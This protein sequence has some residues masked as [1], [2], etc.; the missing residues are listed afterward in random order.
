MP[1]RRGLMISIQRFRHVAIVASDLDV[2]LEFYTSV[3]GFRERSRYE[4]ASDDFR[5]GVGLPHVVAEVVHLGMVDSPVEIEMFQFDDTL[6]ACADRARANLPGYRHIAFVVEDLGAA[7]AQLRDLG[8][9]FFSNP[10]TLGA[11]GSVA[12]IQFVYFKD[13]EGNIVELNQLPP[14]R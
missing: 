8:V 12:G 4:S 10:I 6:A 3:L 11:S 7:C 13:P 5:R 2:M 1:E 14:G 9:Q